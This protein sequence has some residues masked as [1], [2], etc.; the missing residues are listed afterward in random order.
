[1]MT[2]LRLLDGGLAPAWELDPD[3]RRIGREG[4]ARARAALEASRPTERPT[5]ERRA[6]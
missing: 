3:L 5:R 2:Q 6:G 4:V 1:M